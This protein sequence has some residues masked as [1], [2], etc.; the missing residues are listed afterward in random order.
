VSSKSNDNG[1]ALEYFICENIL[2]SGNSKLTSQAKLDQL[3]DAKKLPLIKKQLLT[4]WEETVPKFVSWLKNYTN[5][6]FLTIDRLADNSGKVSD[7]EISYDEKIIGFSIKNNCDDLKHP[8]PFSLAQACKFQKNSDTDILYRD[9]MEKIS[10]KFHRTLPQSENKQNYEN[11]PIEK[12]E[13]YKDVTNLAI[14]S[15]NQWNAVSAAQNFFMFMVNTDFYKI[16]IKSS[17]TK[18]KPSAILTN[19]F[20]IPMPKNMLAFIDPEN[21]PMNNKFLVQ[22]DNDWLIRF[23]IHTAKKDIEK[24]KKVNLKWAVTAVKTPLKSMIL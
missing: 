23:R 13:L 21:N 4:D 2:N 22:F 6:S 16:K 10:I 11:F 14:E 9:Q 5:N 15:L 19:F 7:I 24:N 20:D 8:R 18:N 17:T 3:R 1:R 12:N